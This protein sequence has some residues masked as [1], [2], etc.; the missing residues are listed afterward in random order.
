VPVA[1]SH[2]RFPEFGCIN[3]SYFNKCIYRYIILF[4]TYT[5]IYIYIYIYLLLYCIKI[6]YPEV[7]R[8]MVTEHRLSVTVTVSVA[9]QLRSYSHE[10]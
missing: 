6:M 1:L 5:Y 7:N 2:Q 8:F 9:E 3:K 4:R 10:H